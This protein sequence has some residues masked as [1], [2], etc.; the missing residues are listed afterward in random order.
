MWILANF[1]FLQSFSEVIPAKAL[2]LPKVIHKK[3]EAI[4]FHFKQYLWAYKIL[5]C[6]VFK[7]LNLCFVKLKPYFFVSSLYLIFLFT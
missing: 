2:Y 1:K 5:S 3:I 4:K 6:L 7:H